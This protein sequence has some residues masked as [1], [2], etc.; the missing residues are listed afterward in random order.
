MFSA[1]KSRYYFQKIEKSKKRIFKTRVRI[2]KAYQ[3]SK[4]AVRPQNSTYQVPIKHTRYQVQKACPDIRTCTFILH[5]HIISYGTLFVDYTFIQVHVYFALVILL[6][7]NKKK[8]A[9]LKELAPKRAA[10]RPARQRPR[11]SSRLLQRRGTPSRPPHPPTRADPPRLTRR[12]RTLQVMLERSVQHQTSPPPRC[13]HHLREQLGRARA[14]RRTY[15]P[16]RAPSQPMTR[17]VSRR[18]PI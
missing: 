15:S 18:R 7:H 8:N 10:A 1:L 13:L 2:E 9:T 12:S 11:P 14:W 16:R 5:V 3:M 4:I 17:S 6:K